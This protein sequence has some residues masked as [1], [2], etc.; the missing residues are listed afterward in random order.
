MNWLSREREKESK[1]ANNVERKCKVWTFNKMSNNLEWTKNETK[2]KASNRL[3]A[4][5]RT[6]RNLAK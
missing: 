6:K 5:V 1:M 4:T 2:N 3:S